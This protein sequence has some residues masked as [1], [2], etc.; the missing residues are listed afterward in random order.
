[1][2]MYLVVFAGSLVMSGQGS[3]VRK[4]FDFGGAGEMN[5]AMEVKGN[6]EMVFKKRVRP[7]EKRGGEIKLKRIGLRVSLF[8]CW[9]QLMK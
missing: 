2:Y 5:N 1:M 3:G 8:R 6:T 9:C 4:V 7:G